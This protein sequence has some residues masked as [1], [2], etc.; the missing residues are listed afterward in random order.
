MALVG[1]GSKPASPPPPPVTA[2]P[3]IVPPK[4][5]ARIPYPKA[6]GMF[7]ISGRAVF[8]GEPPQRKPIDFGGDPKVSEYYGDKQLL[9]ER[10]I[11]SNDGALS[12]VV[13]YV[14]KG[15]ERYSFETPKEDVV[16]KME[17][18]RYEPHV[19]GVMVGQ[20]VALKYVDPVTHTA[21]FV[22]R[23]NFERAVSQA[24]EDF[25]TFE[26]AEVCVRFQCDVHKWMDGWCGVFEHPF[27]VVTSADGTF[28][29]NGLMSETY[30]ITAWHEKLGTQS[31]SVT[32]PS[33]EKIEFS[34]K[35]PPPEQ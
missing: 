10:L 15:M 26:V 14:S 23:N 32:L 5:V 24:R 29:L 12:N 30:E 2:P 11:V 35:M 4:P 22:P 21:H 25:K 13:V 1:C 3:V 31:K 7:S 19:F 9:S 17:G 8:V 27:F 20:R 33:T 6:E 16:L 34:F 28:S 18:W